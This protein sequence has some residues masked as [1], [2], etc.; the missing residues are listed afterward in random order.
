MKHRHSI[1]ITVALMSV[2]ALLPA[3][4]QTYPLSENT[5]SNP[6]FVKRFMGSY[7]FE[8]KTEPEITKEEQMLFQEIATLARSGASAAISRLQ[9]ARTPESSAA[10]DYTLANFQMQSGDINGAIRNYKEAIRKF[11]NF[12]RA[13]QNVGLAY[14]QQGSYSDALQYLL[15]AIEIRGGN[16]TLF[17]LVGYCYLNG[18]KYASALDA[19]RQALIFDPDSRDWKLGKLNVLTSMGMTDEAL[20]LL[21]EMIN[22]N[23]D[24]AQKWLLQARTLLAEN[25]TNKAMANLIVVDLLG[26]A[27]GKALSLLGE[28]YVN[29]GLPHLAF[30]P[31]S[32]ALAV[33]DLDSKKVLRMA[34]ILADRTDSETAKSFMADV[35]TKYLPSFSPPEE[36]QYLN[37][38]AKIAL[39]E[40]DDD[41]AA[42]ILKQ[43]VAKD[44]LNGRALI[45]LGKYYQGKGEIE[46]AVFSFESAAKV[47][48][49]RS[50]ALI[51]HARLMVGE[52][53]FET[54]IRLLKE[55]QLVDER[56]YVANYIKNLEAALKTRGSRS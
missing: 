28:L 4:A 5:W 56:D 1:I 36:L 8:T 44:P 27:N 42:G 39:A 51:Q 12:F 38:N 9:S 49:F 52:R 23:P 15:K 24:D 3:Q 50:E 14:V 34:T 16:G 43:V 29:N 10:V 6:E 11:P 30:D 46:E 25:E 31:F 47:D 20:G 26:D 53:D 48:D 19:Y 54:A 33:G 21:Y 55:S 17:G 32:K 45:T 18:G 7:G 41:K 2:T 22:E 35:K 13:Y 40:G 37:L